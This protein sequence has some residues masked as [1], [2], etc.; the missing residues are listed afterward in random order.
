MKRFLATA[1]L[2]AGAGLLPVLAL[3]AQQAPPTAPASQPQAKA[4]EKTATKASSDPIDRIKEEG[5]QRS[6]VM[7]TMSYLTDVIGPR[8]TGSPNMKRANEWTRDK[9]AAWGLANAHLEAWGVPPERIV[10]TESFDRPWYPGEALVTTVLVEQDGRTTL[11]TTVLYASREVR[12]G[13]LKSNMEKGVAA[14][15]DRLAEVLAPLGS[16]A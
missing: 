9:M 11:T 7:A 5:L 1:F 8:L 15:Y 16:E 12:D 3:H 10:N 2:M 4:A 14:S 13:V 6:Q